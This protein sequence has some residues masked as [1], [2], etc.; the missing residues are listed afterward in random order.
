MLHGPQEN[1]GLR[2]DGVL[3]IG[4]QP[5]LRKHM[6]RLERVLFAQR[7]V[8]AGIDQLKR[9][10]HELDLADAAVAELHIAVRPPLLLHVPVDLLLHVADLGD[11]AV[12]EVLPVHEGR[13]AVH[14]LPAHGLVAGHGPGLDQRR[15]LPGLAPGLV[16]DL[17]PAQA[18]GQRDRAAPRAGDAGP[19]GT[20]TRPR[21]SRRWPRSVSPRA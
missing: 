21:S 11:G 15:P 17:V 12:V 1:V 18:L 6:Q 4:D 20:R 7:P 8:P 2:K 10:D 19:R 9:L 14:E 16:I 5:L 13:D 3:L